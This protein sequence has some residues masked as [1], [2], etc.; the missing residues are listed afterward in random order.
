MFKLN[1]IKI[2]DESDFKQHLHSEVFD[3]F[4]YSAGNVK[5]LLNLFLFRLLSDI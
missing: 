5:I 4:Q 3:S 1:S 2:I